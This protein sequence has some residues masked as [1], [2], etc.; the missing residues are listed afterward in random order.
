MRYYVVMLSLAWS[1]WAG[2]P[3]P[4]PVGNVV[5]AVDDAK[6]P[7]PT[8]TAAEKDQ[9]ARYA[10][11]HKDGDHSEDEKRHQTI[12]EIK[13]RL[14]AQPMKWSDEDA[15]LRMKVIT[16]MTSLNMYLYGNS[17]EDEVSNAF[18]TFVAARDDDPAGLVRRMQLVGQ[19]QLPRGIIIHNWRPMVK[20]FLDNA[21]F[22][23][24]T[25]KQRLEFVETWLLPKA[26]K[27]A[28]KDIEEFVKDL[29]ED[30]KTK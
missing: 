20:V 11:A 29:R 14:A 2:E 22:K 19:W 21:K 3:S 18:K 6:V 30:A 4:L 10:R 5:A 15:R 26:P 17:A 7:D 8:P 28:T 25:P 13:R 23:T 27:A 16:D 1:T 9:L 12:A 24:A